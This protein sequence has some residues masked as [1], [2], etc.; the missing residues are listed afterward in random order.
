MYYVSKGGRR[1]IKPYDRDSAVKYAHKWAYG[2]NPA[3]YD[4]EKLGGDCT[5]F[6]S[7]CIYAG[8]GVMNFTPVYGWYY[9]NSYNRTASWTGVNY[10]YR[11]LV[12]NKEEGPFAEEVDI[13]DVRPGDIA[14]LSFSNSNYF[15]HSPVIV[16]V[17]GT[18]AMENILV[19]AHTFNTDYYRLADFEPAYVRFLHS[20]RS[21]LVRPCC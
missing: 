9:I 16:E 18:P 4:F 1:T 19:A 7:Q 2:R 13:A 20:R 15:H 12:N 8:S 17:T 5:N 14:Q 11:F 10:L 6:A 3:Y 21:Y